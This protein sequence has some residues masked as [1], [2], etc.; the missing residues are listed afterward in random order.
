MDLYETYAQKGYWGNLVLGD[1][2][3][4]SV[5]DYPEKVA[6]VQGER[7]VT[8][9]QFGGMVNR[10]AFK[11]LEMGVGKGDFVVIVVPNC[12]E[13][14]YFEYAVAKIGAVSI[15]MVHTQQ[16]HEVGYAIN[17]FN[18]R[19]LVVSSGYTKLDFI[20]MAQ[21][22][23]QQYPSLKNV[24]VV[25]EPSSKPSYPPEMISFDRLISEPAANEGDPEMLRKFRPKGTDLLRVT[26]SAGTTGAPKA[27]MRTHNDSLAS[28]RWDAVFH[29]WGENVLLFFPLGHS[30]GH[31]VGLDL[32]VLLGRQITLMMGK[33][34]AESVLSLIEKEK[35]TAVYLP[36]PLF[37]TIGEAL[38]K[39]PQLALAYN[40]RSLRKFVFGGAQAPSNIIQTVIENTGRPVLQTWGMAEGAVTSTLITDPPDVQAYTIGRIQCPDAKVKVIDEDGK[41]VPAGTP[42]E[43]MYKGPFLFAGYYQDPVLTKKSIDEEGYFHTGD[44]VVLDPFGNIKIVGRLKDLVRRGGEPISA[45]EVED[46]IGRHEKV[47]EVAVVAMPDKR[48]IEKVCAYIVPKPNSTITFDDIIDF[49]KAKGIATFKLP[50]RIEFIDR[51]PRG[52]QKGNVLKARLRE[53]ITNKLKAEGKI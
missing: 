49:M 34:D 40:L 6:M 39:R 24:I 46:L 26:L 42:G 15:P 8:Y 38:E 7:K 4:Q 27:A 53:D 32:Q 18:P 14:A 48:M 17:L 25:R 51:L 11:L 29:D 3:D 41:E 45:V 5:R 44:Q 12:I 35:V 22:L 16:I 28:L 21:Q 9:S 30:T 10:L 36:T 47:A 13:Y 33:F 19:V 52:E 50:E 1:L 37:S 20:D 31:F 2:L 23:Q 43:L